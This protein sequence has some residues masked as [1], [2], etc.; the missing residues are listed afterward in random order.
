[1]SIQALP[2]GV[3]PATLQQ[4]RTRALARID[5]FVRTT[6][7]QILRLAQQPECAGLMEELTPLDKPGRGTEWRSIALPLQKHRVIMQRD[8][9][10]LLNLNHGREAVDVFHGTGSEAVFVETHLPHIAA[11]ARLVARAISSGIGR[12]L[13]TTVRLAAVIT[14]LS[15]ASLDIGVPPLGLITIDDDVAAFT[16]PATALRVT[17]PTPALPILVGAYLQAKEKETA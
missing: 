4:A 1:M 3:D 14:A 15:S 17:G 7:P 10:D 9:A 16:R 11:E 6:S 12:E 8:R 2:T 13:A 5:R